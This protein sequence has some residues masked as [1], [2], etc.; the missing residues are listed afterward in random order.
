[1]NNH[2]H[3]S[4]LYNDLQEDL[5]SSEQDRGHGKRGC[6]ERDSFELRLMYQSVMHHVF[7]ILLNRRRTCLSRTSWRKFATNHVTNTWQN[8]PR[9]SVASEAHV[10][11]TR[12]SHAHIC[13]P[14]LCNLMNY[15]IFYYSTNF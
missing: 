8:E 11:R 4:I 14:F 12:L 7:L 10:P 1:M 3:L 6:T 2:R 13:S 5:R 9:V 15:I